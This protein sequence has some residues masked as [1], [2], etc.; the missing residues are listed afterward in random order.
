M[1]RTL[2]SLGVPAIASALAVLVI[3]L[4]AT[5]RTGAADEEFPAADAGIVP[6]SY[7]ARFDRL[8]QEHVPVDSVAAE[9]TPRHDTRT[10]GEPW[11]A[12]GYDGGFVISPLNP[13]ETPFELKFNM[14]N[15]LRYIG[16]ARDVRTWTNN[17]GNV[18]P[19]TNRSNFE[20]PRGRA[21][22]S[23]FALRP[24]LVYYLSID[25]N[26]VSDNQV[27]FLRYWAGYRFGREV[28]L[29]IG[30]EK[31]PGSRE[32]LASSLQ[33]LGPDRSLA[34][35]FFRPSLSQGIWATGEPIDGFHYQT[36]IANGFNTLGTNPQQLNSRMTFANSIW[37]EPLGTFG[38]AYSDFEYH[39]DPVMRVGG[40]FTYS[41]N[42]GQQGNPELPENASIRLSDGTLLTEVGALAPGV[43]LSAYSVVL[44]AVDL[45]FKYR[46]FSVSGEFYLRDLFSLRANGALPRSSIFDFGG[47]AQVGYFVIPQQFELYSRTS[48]VSGPYGT[49]SEYAGG[50][51][52]FFLRGRQNLRQTFDI[53]W[54]NHSPADQNRTDYRAG[55]TGLLIRSQLQMFF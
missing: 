16:F 31:V 55:D 53:A 33:T 15:Q 3:L 11:Y 13:D 46:G 38:S 35:T 42:D 30:Q 43:S 51:N 14:Q 24:E 20:L 23:G 17:A 7:Q 19:V 40:S 1:T 39:D 44:G 25:Y 48:V 8:E 45:S 32:W 12:A 34:T 5:V 27:N 54:I 26:T 9:C 22:F 18:A 28:S 29:F 50:L 41:P 47:F 21:I 4:V 36:M 52:W 37:Y 6:A 10:I 49:G 2:R